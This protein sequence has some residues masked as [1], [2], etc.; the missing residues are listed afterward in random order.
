MLDIGKLSI[1]WICELNV[2][3][4]QLKVKAIALDKI[5]QIEFNII[6]FMSIESQYNDLQEIG[7]TIDISH[8]YRALDPKDLEIYPYSYN[9]G[10]PCHIINIYGDYMIKLICNDINVIELSE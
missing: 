8:E 10:A 3:N 4:N 6:L 1:S 9:S 2:S 5:I 7:D